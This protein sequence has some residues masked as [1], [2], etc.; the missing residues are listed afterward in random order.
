VRLALGDS[1]RAEIHLTHAVE[2]ATA[3]GDWSGRAHAVEL[4]GIAAWQTGAVTEALW[5]WQAAELAFEELG[6]TVAA[7]RCRGHRSARAG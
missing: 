4:L 6:E 2:R 5:Q 3:A 1:A 7:S